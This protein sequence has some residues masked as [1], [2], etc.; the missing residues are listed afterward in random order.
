M[1]NDPSE[2][3]VIRQNVP[4][5]YFIGV[6]TGASA[7]NHLF[8][9]W[10][11]ILGLNQAQLTGVDLPL[12]ADADQYREVIAQIKYDPLSLGGL[13]TTHKIDLFEAAGD[14]FDK[15]GRYA[16]LCGDVSCISK[17]DGQLIG[18]AVDP[19]SAGSALDGMLDPDCWKRS[20][21]EILCI[22]AGG[23]AVSIVYYFLTRPDPGNRPQRITVVNRS[24]PRLDNLRRIVEKLQV[25]DVVKYVLN[26][27]PRRNDELMAALPPG[28]MVINATGMG[29]DR[30]GSP[31]TDDGVF[32]MSGIAWELNYRGSLEFL[33]QAKAQERQRNLAVHDGWRYFLHGWSDVIGEVFTKQ[34]TPDLF[35]QLDKA[36]EQ[37]KE[38]FGTGGLLNRPPGNTTLGKAS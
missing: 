22:G 32:P 1:H 8:P 25:E 35:A 10:T 3:A 36:A 38:R 17:R 28:S 18:R 20:N 4:T 5:M 29:K 9:L 26:E 31:I 27:D 15:L 2:Y 21:S 12:H 23:S 13:V 24:Q 6:S 19:I 16:Q 11:D 33:H 34:I 30:P 37:I 7:I 14:M